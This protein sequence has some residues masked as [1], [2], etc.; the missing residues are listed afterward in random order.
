MI[1]ENEYLDDI[2]RIWKENNSGYISDESNEK[3]IND[4]GMNQFVWRENSKTMAY[5]IVYCRK[6]FLEKESF[7]NKIKNMSDNT[8][9]IWEIVTD[10]MYTGKGI[11]NKLMQYIINKFENYD[12]YSCIDLRNIPSLKLHEKN[13]FEILY[14]FKGKDNNMHAIL[15]RKSKN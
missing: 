2:R 11:A 1:F 9:Y 7:P 10:K 5:A 14:E 8:A 15:I 4:D 3:A 13:G 12:L 6:D